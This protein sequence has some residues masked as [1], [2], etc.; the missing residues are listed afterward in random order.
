MEYKTKTIDVLLDEIVEDKYD[1]LSTT[2]KL[3]KSD[4]WDFF[5]GFEGRCA[6]EFGTHKGQTTRILSYLFDTVY[7]IN[8]PGGFEKAQALNEDRNNIQYIGYD[9]Y[10]NV[11]TNKFPLHKPI[12]MFFID[13]VH[14][15]DAVLSDF[16]RATNCRVADDE[17]YFVF[18]DYGLERDVFHAVNQL[19][20]TKRLSKVKYIGHSPRH[21]F[22]GHPERVL[23]D[24]EGIITKLNK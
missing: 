22:G 7:T 5:Q 4:L 6:M 2:S 17:V 1:N 10:A 16:V 9:L 19:L 8:L 20:F 12:S 18:D 3:F 23:Q 14:T 13:A 15:F 24:W 21:S 11:E